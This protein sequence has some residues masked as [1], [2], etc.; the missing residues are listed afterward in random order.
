MI[1][2][3]CSCSF[4]ESDNHLINRKMRQLASGRG[5]YGH[6]YMFVFTVVLGMLRNQIFRSNLRASRW[7]RGALTPSF[8]VPSWKGHTIRPLSRLCSQFWTPAMEH[9][10]PWSC[11]CMGPTINIVCWYPR[12]FPITILLYSNMDICAVSY[13]HLTL[14][15]IYSV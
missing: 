5:T 12:W 2:L 15:T 6:Q 7:L 8:L 11:A 3:T 1:F 13:T 4:P 10:G 9:R 14:P